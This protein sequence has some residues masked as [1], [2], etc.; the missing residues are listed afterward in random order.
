MT[1]PLYIVGTGGFSKEV[2]LL[3][4]E[5]AAAGHA[6]WSEILFLSDRVEEIGRT[7]PLGRVAGTDA[8]LDTLASPADVV[9]AVGTPVVRR[10]IAERIAA[11]PR[12]SMPNLVHPG[13]GLDP[14]WVTLGRGNLVTR[15]AVFTVDIT[16]GDNCVFNLNCTV[17]HDTRIG[18]HLVANPGCN[19][20]GGATIGDAVLLGT[21]CQVLEGLS[22]ASD[23]VV[24]AG[25]VV[26]RSIDAPGTWAGVPARLLC[27]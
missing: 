3:A 24:G 13:A 5:I 14:R 10:R 9:V 20:S 17:G 16:V 11:L 23:V 22:V 4:A 1:R 21:G 26:T 12:V 6:R 19:I 18:S 8:L 25:A 27:R 7:M 15:G 2:A